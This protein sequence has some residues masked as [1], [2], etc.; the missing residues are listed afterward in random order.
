MEEDFDFEEMMAKIMMDARRKKARRDA[1]QQA[2]ERVVDRVG[3]FNGDDVPRF[4]EAQDAEMAKGGVDEAMRLEYFPRVAAVSVHKEV[5]ELREA[6]ESWVSF[7]GALLEAYGYTEPEGR[8][9]HEFDRWVASARRH[10]SA[11]EAF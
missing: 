11:M 7:E 2:V 8:G 5:K 9:R 1:A 10:Q 6:H 4:L 3:R